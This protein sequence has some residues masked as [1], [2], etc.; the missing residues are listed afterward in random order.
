MRF[1][2]GSGRSDLVDDAGR[3]FWIRMSAVSQSRL[4]RVHVCRAL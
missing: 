2:I 4:Q 3:K 1:S